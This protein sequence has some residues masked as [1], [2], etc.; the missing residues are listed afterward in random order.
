MQ[1]EVPFCSPTYRAEYFSFVFVKDGTGSYTTGDLTFP[2]KPRTIYFTNPGHVKSF[3]IEQVRDAHIIMLS[4]DFLRRN[5]HPDVFGEFPFLL[6]E[7]FAPWYVNEDEFSEFEK[8]YL[9]I[10]EESQKH[11]RYKDKILGNLL[12]V[13]LLK[14]KDRFCYTYCAMDEGDRNS[15]IVRSF[16]KILEN[17]FKDLA[18]SD[19]KYSYHVQDYA[20]ELKLH[21]NYLNTVIKNKTGKTVNE[22]INKRMTSTASVLLK[23]S[24]LSAKEVSLRLG[25]SQPTHFSRFFKKHTGQSPVEFKKKAI[26]A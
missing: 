9:Q 3:S 5:I 19:A 10:Y 7:T 1:R 26:P 23:N 15:Q 13:L 25:F 16:K 4:E 18:A 2:F 17:Q 21:P 24:G 14:M 8:L 11:S 6:A 20:D 12:A 22:W